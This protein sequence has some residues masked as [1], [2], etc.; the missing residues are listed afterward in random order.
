MSKQGKAFSSTCTYSISTFGD[1]VKSTIL[2]DRAAAR[3]MIGYWHDIVVC[4]SV[5]PSVCLAV[6]KLRQGVFTCV[7]WKVMPCLIPHG[8]WLQ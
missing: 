6:T 1:S 8:S 3:S 7:G 5:R 4:P 2:A